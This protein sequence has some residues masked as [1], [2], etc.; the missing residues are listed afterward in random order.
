MMCY[1]VLF[2]AGFLGLFF[3]YWWKTLEVV[4]SKEFRWNI[5]RNK[6]QAPIIWALIGLVI[7]LL[8]AV[9]VPE[10]SE[11]IS[12]NTPFSITIDKGAFFALGYGLGF[13]TKNTQK[14]IKNT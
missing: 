3:Y 7:L 9:F 6:N 14:K 2:L 4:K 8:I 12:S 5:F 13:V 11:F 10:A 1:L